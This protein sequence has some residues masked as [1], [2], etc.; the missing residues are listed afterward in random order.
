VEPPT[1]RPDA[2]STRAD[3]DL[4][5]LLLL[6]AAMRRL[7]HQAVVLSILSLLIYSLLH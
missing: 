5:N 7:A 1:H 3:H 4:A 2:A 6:S